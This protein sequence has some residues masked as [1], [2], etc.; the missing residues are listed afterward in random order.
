MPDE[1][2]AEV[3][4]KQETSEVIGLDGKSVNLNETSLAG[5]FDKIESGKAEGKTA[6]EAIKAPDR[7]LEVKQE[8]KSLDAQLA[9]DQK[10]KDEVKA[11]VK[12]DE[13]V[14]PEEEL[15]VLP[16]DKPK[17]AQR[18]KA[19]LGK[20]KEWESVATTTKK[21]GE[22]KATK[23]A[24][25]E[26]K[27]SEVKT[28]DPKVEEETR[29]KLDELQMYRRRYELDKDPEVKT[30]F[31]S[32]VEGAE[33]SIHEVLKR[34][35]AGEALFNLIKEEGGWNKF[36]ESNRLVSVPDDDGGTKQVS[37]AELADA[38]LQRLP[39]G[40]RK[41]IESAMM[42]QVQT[43]RDRE[44]YFKEQQDGAI[45]YFKKR[46]EEAKNGT[47]AQ[48][49]QVEEAK[50]VID[51]WRK[52]MESAD[53]LKDREIN[54]KLTP[55]QKTAAV[56]HNKVNADI[57]A[58]IAK[59]IEVKDLPGMLEIFQDSARYHDEKRTAASLKQELDAIKAE[60]KAKSE[61]IV[62]FKTGG[63]STQKSGSIVTATT[64]DSDGGKKPLTLDEELE[65]MDRNR[66]N[67]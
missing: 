32:R 64:K 28:I 58:R 3:I 14:V 50:K 39:L 66:G 31:D 36:A 62:K 26:K 45:E 27:L 46:E 55:A 65:L 4:Q 16:H 29:K 52:T 44:R 56:E 10:A 5:M 21:E 43:R 49:K 38:I 18:I 6:E 40:E 42:E 34:R 67:E 22:E 41:A 51:D 7:S 57:K 13:P 59:A 20:V 9:S 37:T 15:Q 60:L 25:L 47:L 8:S 63:R 54:D 12:S 11:E 1:V 17:T 53:W 24:E 33:A 23:L 48:Q 61:E 30:K 35:N 19:L 2:K